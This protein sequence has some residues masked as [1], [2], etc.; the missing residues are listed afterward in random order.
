MIRSLRGAGAFA[1]LG[2]A[3]LTL[4]ACGGGSGDD[5]AATSTGS[6]SASSSAS[7]SVTQAPVE[8]GDGTLTIGTLL[9]QTGSLAFLG[10]PEFAGVQLALNDINA[11][12]GYNGKDVVYNQTDSGDTTT[13]IAS[14]SV[15][16]LLSAKTDAIIGAASSG[17][18][19]TVI[20]AITGA[21]VTQ[22][23]PANTSPDFTTYNDRGLYW[24][25]APSD[26]LQGRVMGDLLLQDGHLDVA[27]ITLDDPYGS[28][29]QTNIEQA[30]TAGG[31]QIVANEVFNP[32][33]ATFDSVASEVAAAQPEAIVVIG[34]EQTVQI[35]QALQT[36][37]I[38]PSAVPTYFVDG[39]LSNYKDDFPAGTLK[40]VKGTL[41][42][43]A[44]S[45]DFRQKLLQVDPSL[46]DFSYAPESYDATVL[47]A[48]AAHAA[49][50]DSG[51]AIASQLQAVSEGGTKCTAYKEC[52]DLLNAG[53]DIDYDG[54]S[55][56][57]EFSPQGD[58]TQ[59]T[60]GI[61]EYGD[62]N[63]YTNV[64]YIAGSL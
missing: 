61:Y 1:V 23:S 6:E 64:D 33:A 48:L 60:I 3:S 26:V 36:Q 38:G 21:G 14:Q 5:P 40:G 24:R 62:D 34:F 59:A 54:F 63:T 49:K 31:G 35:I 37:N 55:G 29:L 43:A 30:L 19:F 44:T 28:G 16:R 20:D 51:T 42:G 58:P 9:P 2:V 50:D 39:N 4:A 22:I 47:A 41:P 7:A 18:S 46:T 56:P 52:L 10:P 25:T 53:T 13:D 8:P 57:I 32:D 27:T 12:G 15:Q 11:A 17:V 45:D